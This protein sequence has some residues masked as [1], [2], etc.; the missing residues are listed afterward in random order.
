[1]KVHSCKL[2][3]KHDA[4][5]KIGMMP[6]ESISQ[7][8]NEGQRVQIDLTEES[9][10]SESECD[11]I[12]K[13]A[14]SEGVIQDSERDVPIVNCEEPRDNG[15]GQGSNALETYKGILEGLIKRRNLTKK[16]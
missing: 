2:V 8:Y 5:S 1:M 15:E 11:K 10:E 12:E 3:L 16:N 7:V 4:D 6:N 14:S 13:N 9:S